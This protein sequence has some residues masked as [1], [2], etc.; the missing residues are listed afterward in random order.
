MQGTVLMA[1]LQPAPEVY[2]LFDDILLLCEGKPSPWT[3]LLYQNAALLNASHIIAR[4][5]NMLRVCVQRWLRLGTSLKPPY[6]WCSVLNPS[7][8]P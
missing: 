5:K 4:S 6:D 3:H 2:H 8:V 7:Q 1:L